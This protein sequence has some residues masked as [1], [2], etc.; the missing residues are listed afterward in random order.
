MPNRDQTG[1]KG[2]GA[3]TGQGRGNCGGNKRDDR[4]GGSCVRRRQQYLNADGENSLVQQMETL[5]KRMD[6]VLEK[7]NE[8]EKSK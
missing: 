4:N 3:R 7:L 5:T 2:S 1:P 8:S 6:E